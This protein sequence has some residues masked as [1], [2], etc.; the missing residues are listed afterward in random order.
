M[1]KQK[2]LYKPF[3]FFLIDF[4]LTWIPLW[5]AVAGINRGWFE[6]NVLFMGVD[7]ILPRI[8]N[9]TLDNNQVAK[10]VG[11]Q[12][13]YPLMPDTLKYVSRRGRDHLHQIEI[14]ELPTK[15]FGAQ[16]GRF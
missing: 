9:S 16:A 14:A 13:P 8:I 6:F 5:L 11:Y 12:A 10:T 4:L 7:Q 1:N 15:I 3:R 2:P